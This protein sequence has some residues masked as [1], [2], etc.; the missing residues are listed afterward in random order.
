MTL[1]FST[2]LIVK[3]IITTNTPGHS[4][5]FKM[6]YMLTGSVLTLTTLCTNC[7]AGSNDFSDPD[8]TGSYTL[9]LLKITF[10]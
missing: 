9:D 8:D 4:T 3:T 10:T 6:E 2:A 1:A 5:A 7:N